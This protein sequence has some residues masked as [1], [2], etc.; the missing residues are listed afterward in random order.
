MKN[1]KF[2]KKKKSMLNNLRYSIDQFKIITF[3]TFYMT[4]LMKTLKANNSI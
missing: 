4:S 2:C 1:N 3:F